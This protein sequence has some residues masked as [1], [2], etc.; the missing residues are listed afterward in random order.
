MYEN[1]VMSA[2]HEVHGQQ[3]AL[4]SDKPTRIAQSLPDIYV[5]LV[6]ATCQ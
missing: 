5:Y 3:S 1:N 4:S 6:P 2:V